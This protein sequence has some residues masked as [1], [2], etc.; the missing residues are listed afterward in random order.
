MVK[1]KRPWKR[2]GVQRRL[3]RTGFIYPSLTRQPN[4]QPCQDT[5]HKASFPTKPKLLNHSSLMRS[6]SG[7]HQPCALVPCATV[8]QHQQPERSPATR[9]PC[10]RQQL[11]LDEAETCSV[12][13]RHAEERRREDRFVFCVAN[14]QGHHWAHKRRA[15]DH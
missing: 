4:P 3:R 2:A 6:S 11:K 13:R 8:V 12:P 5:I 7:P 9:R 1:R 14:S 10:C 15:F